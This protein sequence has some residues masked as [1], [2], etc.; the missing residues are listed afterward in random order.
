[1]QTP[2]VS[3]RGS[4]LRR[5]T[6]ARAGAG[7]LGTLAGLAV[8]GPRLATAQT[9]VVDDELRIIAPRIFQGLDPTLGTSA[10]RL[11]TVG[12]AEGLLRITPQGSLECELAT[13]CDPVDPTTW[14]VELRP[15]VTFWSGRPVDAWAIADSLERTRTLVP[16]AANLLAGVRIEPIGERTLVFRSDTPIPWLPTALAGEWLVIHNADSYGPRVNA[17]SVGAADLT[18]YFR[19]TAFEPGTQALFQRNR[20]YWGV[21]PRASRVRFGEIVDA[22]ARTLAGLT[23]EAH[24]VRLVNQ[25]SARQIERSRSTRLEAIPADT[26]WFAFMN[27]DRPFFADVRVRQ[28]LSWAAD[29]AELVTLAH[30]EWANPAPSWLS[31]HP[32]YPEAK[33]V[34]YTRQDLTKAAQLLDEAGWRLAPGSRVRARDGVPLRFTLLWGTASPKSLAEVLQ[35]QWGKIGIDVQVP[36]SQNTDYGQRRQRGDWDMALEGWGTYGDPAA[37]LS[38]HVAAAGDLNY[39]KLV[40]LVTEDL[41]AG[42][43]GIDDPEERRQQALRLNARHAELVPFIPLTQLIQLNAVSRKVRNYTPHFLPW[44]YEVHPDLWAAV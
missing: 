32:E 10:S 37:V 23:G 34:G 16:F 38:R 28:A 26:I 6:F 30:E 41:L 35:A 22:E 8:R 20:G 21:Q 24:V 29:R 31:T 15:N 36:G 33:K 14:Q 39:A 13:S 11:R 40:D 42:F 1:M 2:Q 25:A 9:D 44:V 12:A 7:A 5:R 27:F 3:H 43:A 19:V 4:A 17:F 18:G